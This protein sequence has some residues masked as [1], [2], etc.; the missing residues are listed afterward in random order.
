LNFVTKK[1]TIVP[2][3]STISDDNVSAALFGKARRAVLSL[4][5]SHSDEALYL[6]EL[7]RA[8]GVGLGA[9]QRGK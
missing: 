3:M 6:R 9:V 2:V 5:Y 4:L 8:T 1:G 7:A